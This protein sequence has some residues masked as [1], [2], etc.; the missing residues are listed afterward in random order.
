MKHLKDFENK[1]KFWIVP[2]DER[3]I[4][5]LKDIGCSKKFIEYQ[6]K[7]ENIF[8]QKYVFISYES[9]DEFDSHNGWGWS[10]GA[11]NLNNPKLSIYSNTHRYMGMVNIEDYEFIS[12]KYNL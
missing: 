1:N 8:K 4:K 9:Y 3:F 10:T 6:S 2:T 5:S 7:N 12:D 11:E